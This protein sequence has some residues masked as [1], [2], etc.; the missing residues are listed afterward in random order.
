MVRILTSLVAN[1]KQGRELSEESK[2][3]GKGGGR[4]TGKRKETCDS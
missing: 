2:T 4:D 1:K 3:A